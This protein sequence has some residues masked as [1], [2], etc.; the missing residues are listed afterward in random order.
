MKASEP[1]CEKDVSNSLENLLPI[2]GKEGQGEMRREEWRAGHRS[3][4]QV[5]GREGAS[6]NRE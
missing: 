1:R 6:M 4:A 2:L 5:G 3:G